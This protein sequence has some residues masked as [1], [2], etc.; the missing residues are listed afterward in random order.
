MSNASHSLF[1]QPRK[2]SCRAHA[3]RC[4]FRVEITG[5][6][7]RIHVNVEL[8]HAERLRLRAGGTLE[9]VV[10]EDERRMT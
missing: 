7:L 9:E 6:V 4:F 1:E 2:I 8:G 3:F 5:L 10:N